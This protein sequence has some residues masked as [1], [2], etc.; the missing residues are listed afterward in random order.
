[1]DELQR[2][3]TQFVPAEDRIRLAGEGVGG[4][5]QVL[6]L[7]RRL[8]D[9]L[10]PVLLCWLEERMPAQ[11][12]WQAGLMQSFA[13]QQ[14]ASAALMPQVPV[15]GDAL[16][17]SWLVVEMDIVR[18]VNQLELRCKGAMGEQ[19]SFVLESQ[20]LRQWLSIIHEAYRQAEWPLA[21]WSQ[22]LIVSGD[23]MALAP[24]GTMH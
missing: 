15:C 22:W 5:A 4:N 8:A 17:A 19:A 20:S 2:I 24:V 23:A 9:R 16:S 12:A 3:T 10:M 1:M 11:D 6:W 18:G 13:Q 14:A 21:V 7:T